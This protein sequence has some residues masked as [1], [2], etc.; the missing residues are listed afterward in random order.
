VSRWRLEFEPLPAVPGEPPASVRVRR[1][2]KFALRVLRLRCVAVRE[3]PPDPCAWAG[4]LW[5]PDA[6]A[7]VLACC[8]ATEAGCRALLADRVPADGW[9]V[10]PKGKVPGEGC[11]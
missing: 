1:L 10:L 6:G 5:L 4:W 8:H 7:W 2:L 11:G 9:R 3:P